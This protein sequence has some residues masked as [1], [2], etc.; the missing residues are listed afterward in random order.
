MGGGGGGGGRNWTKGGIAFSVNGGSCHKYHF[1]RNK[2][3][4]V[5]NT[6]LP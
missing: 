3:F 5:T 6:C 2:S 1:C 4:V